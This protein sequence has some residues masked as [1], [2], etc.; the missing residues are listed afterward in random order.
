M[1]DTSTSGASKPL[2]EPLLAL[3]GFTKSFGP[4]EAMKGVSLEVRSG[5]VMGLLGDNGAGKS[6]LV[7]AIAGVQPADAGDATFE[8]RPVELDSPQAATGLGIAT[9]YQDLAL[10]ENLD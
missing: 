10:C 4:V 9:V 6:T 5:E 2:S 8:G 1:S 7:K 3:K